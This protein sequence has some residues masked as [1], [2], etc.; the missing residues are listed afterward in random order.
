MSNEVNISGF[1]PNQLHC[2]SHKYAV[3]IMNHS[4]AKTHFTNIWTY[5]YMCIYCISLNIRQ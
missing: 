3:M 4:S 5:F 1:D 2:P